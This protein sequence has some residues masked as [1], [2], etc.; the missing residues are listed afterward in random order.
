M[1]KLSFLSHA[2]AVL[3]IA[4]SSSLGASASASEPLFLKADSVQGTEGLSDVISAEFLFETNENSVRLCGFWLTDDGYELP[5]EHRWDLEGS[6]LVSQGKVVGSYANGNIF[7]S[8]RLKDGSLMVFDV[9]RSHE[10]F[11]E[12]SYSQERFGN[13]DGD[14]WFQQSPSPALEGLCKL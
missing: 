4:A 12:L 1:F 2:F 7:V 14:G 3:I 5:F 13:T 8:D 11:F 10:T 9:S 6:N